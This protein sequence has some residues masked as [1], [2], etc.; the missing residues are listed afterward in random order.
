VSLTQ[1]NQNAFART[2]AAEIPITIQMAI[3][4]P[5]QETGFSTSALHYAQDPNKSECLTDA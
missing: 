4:H 1:S 5:V 3:D 2:L